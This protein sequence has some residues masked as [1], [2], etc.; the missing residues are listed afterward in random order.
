MSF[1]KGKIYGYEKVERVEYLRQIYK[2]FEEDIG[3]CLNLIKNYNQNSGNNIGFWVSVRIIMPVIESVAKTL[4]TSPE[5]VLKN[6]GVKTPHLMWDMFRNSLTHGDQLNSAQ[7]SGTKIR[8]GISIEN[9]ECISSRG[10][11][12]YDAD[13]IFSRLKR[14]ILSEIKKGD[15][16]LIRVPTVIK[17]INPSKE[18]IEEFE[19]AS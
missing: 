14:L 5:N 9:F 1:K 13:D 11:I 7:L 18:I 6:M 3:T 2:R 8:W 12:H 4:D 19:L 17:Y 10:L 15:K 16:S